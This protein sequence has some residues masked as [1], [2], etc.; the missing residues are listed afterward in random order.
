MANKSQIDGKS[1]TNLHKLEV[2]LNAIKLLWSLKF[3][4]WWWIHCKSIVN[5]HES[6]I[7]NFILN[8][9]KLLGKRTDSQIDDWTWI[10]AHLEEHHIK[11]N[12]IALENYTFTNQGQTR[13]KLITNHCESL[14]FFM[15]PLGLHTKQ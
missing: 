5:H 2:I 6:F 1:M 3:K 12:K 4:N 7:L 15:N 13:C 14:Q 10:F 8:K 11:H 9:I